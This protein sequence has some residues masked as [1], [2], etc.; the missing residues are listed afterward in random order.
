MIS[1]ACYFVE[2][3]DKDKLVDVPHL[4]SKIVVILKLSTH[5]E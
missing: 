2:G 5:N 3:E 1:I 4:Y